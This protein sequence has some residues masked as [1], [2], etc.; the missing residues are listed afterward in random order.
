MIASVTAF[1]VDYLK[2]KPIADVLLLAL[3]GVVVVQ[4]NGQR[5]DEKVRR[6]SIGESHKMFHD[7]LKEKDERDDR[8]TEL[9]LSVLT[10]IKQETKAVKQEAQKTTE[11]VQ[12][13]PK[14]AKAAAE[15][16]EETNEHNNPPGLDRT[17]TDKLFDGD[18][19]Y[20]ILRGEPADGNFINP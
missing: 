13:I 20:K 15:K 10:G 8:R 9:L 7:V 4:M 6:E 5:E 3:L 1:L 18:V 2:G 14:A 19:T 11:A 17:S 12:S 16:L